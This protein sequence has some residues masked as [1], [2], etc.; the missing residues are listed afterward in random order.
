MYAV[1][2]KCQILDPSLSAHIFRVKVTTDTNVISVDD[3]LEKCIFVQVENNC[4]ITR[5]PTGGIP[6]HD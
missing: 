1:L 5:F 2:Y 3:L 6:M 4:H